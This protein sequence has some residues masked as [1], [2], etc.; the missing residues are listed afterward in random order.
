[1]GNP[2]C[3]KDT[4]ANGTSV[5]CN[6]MEGSSVPH[7]G[8]GKNY[9]C[10]SKTELSDSSIPVPHSGLRALPL[11]SYDQQSGTSLLNYF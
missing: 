1:M 10:S 5:Q 11:F 7:L 2:V 9:S 3:G 8:Y 4:I 6:A